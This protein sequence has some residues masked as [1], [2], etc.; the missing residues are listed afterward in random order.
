[1]HRPYRDLSIGIP[2]WARL[3]FMWR[4][5]FSAMRIQRVVRDHQRRVR[6]AKIIQKW[7]VTS[8]YDVVE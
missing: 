3:S 5:A 2:G 4:R 1:M 7:W 8:S 6:A